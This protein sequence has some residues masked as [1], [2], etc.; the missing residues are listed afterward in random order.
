[1]ITTFPARFSQCT[2]L[3]YLNVRNNHIRDF[4]LS[5]RYLNAHTFSN[6]TDLCSQICEFASLEILDLG[7]NK[8][9]LL[10][11]ALSKLTSLKVL[12]LQKNRIE[13][14]LHCFTV[15]IPHQGLK[16]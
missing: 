16:L 3:R 13:D 4:P 2:S 10:S 8:L 9:R 5:V 1:M 11:P 7:R 12:S 14:L 15:M 6:E